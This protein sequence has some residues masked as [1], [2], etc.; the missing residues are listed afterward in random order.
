MKYILLLFSAVTI[1]AFLP[2]QQGKTITIVL[3][4]SSWNTVVK[5]LSK[6][7]FEESAEVINTIQEQAT[8]QLQDQMMPKTGQGIDSKKLQWD[9]TKPKKQ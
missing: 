4:V 2:P 9:S 5:G 7:P 8:R 6:L 1:T 3:P